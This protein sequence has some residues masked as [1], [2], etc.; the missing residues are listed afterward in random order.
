MRTKLTR[1]IAGVGGNQGAAMGG[2]HPATPPNTPVEMPHF[3][4]SYSPSQSYPW[5]TA[6]YQELTPQW[7]PDGALVAAR[8]PGWWG[9]VH[10]AGIVSP[11]HR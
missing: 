10:P 11:A 2:Y 7:A 1:R 9:Q 6:V 3:Q 5:G 8:T 4:L